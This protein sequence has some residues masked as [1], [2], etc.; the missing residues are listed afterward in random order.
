MTGDWIVARSHV[1]IFLHEVRLDVSGLSIDSP[2]RNTFLDRP[3]LT[4]RY[5]A[6]LLHMGHRCAVSR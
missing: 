6:F 3:E 5:R 1:A 4:H 2:E